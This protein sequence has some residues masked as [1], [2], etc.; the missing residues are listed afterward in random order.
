DR[1]AFALAAER[2][3]DRLQVGPVDVLH[4]D[5]VRG[6]GHP[7]VE[8]AD[9]VGVLEL[10]RDARLV[11]EHGDELLV[12][13]E[14]R[15]DALDRDGLL[16]ATDGGFG[17]SA[18]DLGHASGVDL[19]GNAISLVVG[20]PRARLEPSLSTLTWEVGEAKGGRRGGGYSS[21]VEEAGSSLIS[22]RIPMP[23]EPRCWTL[24]CSSF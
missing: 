9:D 21:L 1:E 16:H 10:H 13:G 8:D 15:Q 19:V 20:H 11:E 3:E 23:P 22:S 14:R 4:D 24:A 12:L 2:L 17:D 7:D 6:V 18:I 5:E